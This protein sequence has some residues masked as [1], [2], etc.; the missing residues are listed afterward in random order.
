MRLDLSQYNQRLFQGKEAACKAVPFMQKTLRPMVFTPTNEVDTMAVD[1]YGRGY[2]NPSFAALCNPKEL[3]YGIVHE[4]LHCELLHAYRREILHPICTKEQALICNIAADMCIQQMLFDETQHAKAAIQEPAGLV[5]VEDFQKLYPNAGFVRNLTME[6]YVGILTRVRKQDEEEKQRQP[7]TPQDCDDG[8]NAESDEGNGSAEPREADDGS[9]SG[10]CQPGKSSKS[11]KSGSGESGESTEDSDWPSLPKSGLCSPNDTG[12]NC[13]GETKDYEL[14]VTL[15]DLARH[16]A[17]QKELAQE[18][19]SQ[20][21]NYSTNI[22]KIAGNVRQSLAI[23]FGTGKD[24]FAILA[25]VVRTATSS[26]KGATSRTYRK[27]SRLILP[28]DGKLRGRTHSLPNCTVVVDTSGSMQSWN[29]QDEALSVIAKAIRHLRSPRII[30]ADTEMQASKRYSA[31]KQFEWV[32]GGGTDMGAAVTDAYK[33]DRPSVIVLI[34]DGLTPWPE[35]L[36]CKLIIALVGNKLSASNRND[37]PKWARVVD[38]QTDKST[39]R[40]DR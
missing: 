8:D 3:G 11:S 34:T 14:P 36:G 16:D 7:Q 40:R 23:K 21:D 17:Q 31:F 28:N 33:A 38:C 29:A 30:C 5:R 37:V 13:G 10:D 1:K 4:R 20:Q 27:P 24:P 26:N 9:G 18:L 25:S 39:N 15:A 35:K 6:Q 22:G 19:Q 2:L 32:G 12:S